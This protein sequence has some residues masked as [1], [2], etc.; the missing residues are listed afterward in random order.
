MY[1]HELGRI[2][3]EPPLSHLENDNQY[4]SEIL[5]LLYE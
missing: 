4:V 5:M 3:L 1:G 2:K